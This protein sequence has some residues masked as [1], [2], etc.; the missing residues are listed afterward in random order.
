MCDDSCVCADSCVCVMIVVYVMIVV[1]VMIV[2][3]IVVCVMIVVS[4]VV[5]I[6]GCGS[7]TIS[8]G[9]SP[10][11]YVVASDILLIQALTSPNFIE[12]NIYSLSHAAGKTFLLSMIRHTP[13]S[14][15][16]KEFIFSDFGF[17]SESKAT[18]YSYIEKKTCFKDARVY[19][20]YILTLTMLRW[21][22]LFFLILL[23]LMEWKYIYIYI[24]ISNDH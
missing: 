22:Q 1:C 20:F 21:M 15:V 16:K 17:E 2:V 24:Y 18:Q 7:S 14:V 3:M 11:Q 4:I 10:A 9:L 6:V 23:G 8:S 19:C 12:P 13:L 5:M